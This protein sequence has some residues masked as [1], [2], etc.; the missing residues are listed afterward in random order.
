MNGKSNINLQD[1]FKP[2]EKENSRDLVF[3]ERV[4]VE[5]RSEDSTISP[6]S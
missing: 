3:D 1:V 2:G 5:G 6:S 4:P